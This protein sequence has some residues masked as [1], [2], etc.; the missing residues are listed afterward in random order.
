LIAQLSFAYPR[1]EF[2]EGAILLWAQEL[3]RF[4]FEDGRVAV[5]QIARSNWFFPSLAELLHEIREVRND[6]VQLE[7][8]ARLEAEHQS[9][10]AEGRT[11]KQLLESEDV[12]SLMELFEKRKA[13]AASEDDEPTE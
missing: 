5:M 4:D 12:S 8:Q 6:R 9:A 13:E 2:S 7:D 1:T 11:L 3:E 10:L